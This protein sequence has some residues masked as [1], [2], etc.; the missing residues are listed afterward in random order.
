MSKSTKV[1]LIAVSLCLVAGCNRAG[2]N[3]AANKAAA[4]QAS[5]NVAP[6]NTQQ[7]ANV[8]AVSGNAGLY[9]AAGG[10][11]PR[12]G[13]AT[14]GFGAP[15]AALLEWVT[16]ILGPPDERLPQ[17]DDCGPGVREMVSWRGGLTLFFSDTDFIGW[18]ASMPEG[19][20]VPVRF[21]TGLGPG[22]SRADL[23][24]VDNQALVRQATEL[25][26]AFESEQPDARIREMWSG[27]TCA[28]EPGDQIRPN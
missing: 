5:N 18:S 15:K 21:E 20:G 23:A 13:A 14:E 19:G 6:A 26:L 11:A 22:A 1:A 28:Q 3:M 16:A 8:G 2:S 9:L 24:S 25:Q 17:T 10:I 4:V 12:G 27:Q 7:G